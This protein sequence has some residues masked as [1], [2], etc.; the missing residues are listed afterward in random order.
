MAQFSDK[1]NSVLYAL[2]S[3][4]KTTF[5]LI[6]ILTYTVIVILVSYSS[7]LGSWGSSAN[8]QQWDGDSWND[9]QILSQ[10]PHPYD[11]HANDDVYHFLL[12]K[13]RY[14]QS[15]NPDHIQ[16]ESD[17]ANS[18][19]FKQ[20][21]VFNSSSTTARI[22]YFES[23]NIYVKIK[24]LQ[25]DSLTDVL[26]SAH[27]DSVPTSYGT[28]DDGMGIA[29]MLG[30][31][32]YYAT[33]KIKP[34]R[35]IIF[36][37]NNNEEFGL[38]G[39]TAFFNHQWSKNVEAFINLEGTGG[40]GKSILFRTTDY[41]IARYYKSVPSPFASS[42]FQQG[43]SNGLVKSETDYKV[44]IQN[45]LRGFDI[46]FY[47]PRD[48]YHTKRDSIKST[49]KSSLYH[50]LFNSLTL[51]QSLSNEKN[52]YDNDSPDYHK[53]PAVFFDLAAFFFI[54]FPL[55]QLYILNLVLIF[56]IPTIIGLFL[57]IVSR[58][59]TWVIKDQLFSSIIRFPLSFILSSITTY[60][61]LFLLKRYN[62]LIIS[63]DYY[64][65][66][67]VSTCTFIFIN[68]LLLYLFDKFL[69]VHDQKLMILLELTIITWLLLIFDT[70]RIQPSKS[71]N[72]GEYILTICF[73]CLSVPTIF[74]LFI[75]SLKKKIPKSYKNSS[76][77][78]PQYGSTH[79]DDDDDDDQNRNINDSDNE[80]IDRESQP[81]LSNRD[82]NQGNS[83]LSHFTAVSHNNEQS[84]SPSPSNHKIFS[85][86]NYDWSI[87]FLLL[88]PVF[89]FFVY[90]I[91][92]RLLEG[93]SQTVQ[94]SDNS[95][96]FLFQA[97]F[98]ISALLT[99]PLL[100]FVHKIKFFIIGIFFVIIVLGNLF[101]INEYPF[102]YAKPLK[103]RFLQ[104]INLDTTE[105]NSNIVIFSKQ[106]FM[107]S[108]LE[109]L[110]S[111]KANN[112]N[113]SCENA[114]DGM[115]NC[116]YKGL[117]PNLISGTQKS[118]AL[119]DLFKIEILNNN[120]GEQ[121][122]S[123]YEPLKADL[124]IK[125][126]DNRNCVLSFNSTK[127]K[128]YLY[129]K[130]PLRTVKIFHDNNQ[131]QNN[132]ALTYMYNGNELFRWFKGIDEVQL[133]KVD[134]NQSNYHIELQWLPR[135]VDEDGIDW[136]QDEL[137]KEKDKKLGVEVKCYWGE[138]DQPSVIDGKVHR[139]VPALDELLQYVPDYITITNRMKGLVE[140]T[141]HFEL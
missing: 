56:F 124:L 5:S 95:V 92:I 14:Y 82:Q 34:L 123:P 62:P 69:K 115:E 36:N 18:S 65:P 48:L 24:G 38:L 19:L 4:R 54:V 35:N 59:N 79:D 131:Y 3:F 53:T 110:P 126:K 23:G 83:T 55:T 51:L 118:T 96:A 13:V 127:Y 141:R 104:K 10:F 25:G 84:P 89:A 134:W 91:S 85:T 26:I 113:V 46:A 20:K 67:L 11:S 1:P 125:V 30:I 71:K 119:D 6:A 101:L 21:D 111:V 45:G 12:D 109:D 76:S 52:S 74:G 9:L 16:V 2:F 116:Y 42:V 27:Y 120:S 68:Y 103:V 112:Q 31:L 107:K 58:K 80:I 117:S 44:Y 98:M 61:L 90:S 17:F 97:I 93:L 29:S 60:F 139:K 75:L 108:I 64:L 39:A 57:L 41:N 8:N 28:T 47:R 138:Y 100:P 49:T 78:S 133:H 99:L 102:S 129:G 122:L 32:N 72:T 40:G 50:M 86:L 140:L 81:L 63:K 94:E 37:F 128:S 114:G 132:S 130:S 66:L 33:F 15:L 136:N 106:G 105:K 121:N 88:V 22:I 7:A 73:L 87:Q 77:S 135:W 137:D 70:F 43:F